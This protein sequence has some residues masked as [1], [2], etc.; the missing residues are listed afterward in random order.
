MLNLQNLLIEYF[1]KDLKSTYH[2]NYGILEPQ[3]GE[4]VVWAGRLALENIANSDSLY[5]LW[6]LYYF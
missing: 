4:I 5:H 2:K 6:L 1:V 3:F